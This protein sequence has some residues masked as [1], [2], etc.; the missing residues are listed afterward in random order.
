LQSAVLSHQQALLD[1]NV[2]ENHTESDSSRPPPK[3]VINKPIAITLASLE[4]PNP[5]YDPNHALPF[6]RPTKHKRSDLLDIASLVFDYGQR[7]IATGKS[8]LRTH[9]QLHIQCNGELRNQ[10]HCEIYRLTQQLFAHNYRTKLSNYRGYMMF[11]RKHKRRIPRH[12]IR[13]YNNLSSH[14]HNPHNPKCYLSSGFLSN[15]MSFALCTHQRAVRDFQYRDINNMTFPYW[16]T[17]NYL[18]TQAHH[19]HFEDYRRSGATW[20]GVRTFLKDFASLD[21]D[22]RKRHASVLLN[23][24]LGRYMQLANKNKTLSSNPSMKKLYENAF[25]SNIAVDVGSFKRAIPGDLFVISY[26]YKRSLKHKRPYLYTYQHWGLIVEPN[27]LSVLHNQTPGGTWGDKYQQWGIQHGRY[28]PDDLQYEWIKE[29][30]RR[31]YVQR[32]FFV[33]RVNI[34]YMLFAKR[35]GFNVYQSTNRSLCRN[36][37]KEYA[38]IYFTNMAKHRKKV[39]SPRDPNTPPEQGI[40]IHSELNAGI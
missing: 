31:R 23:H 36:W 14:R 21:V 22:T 24:I 4:L 25:C 15:C 2:T 32:I 34:H 39:T 29:K 11:H 8:L 18:T 12:L 37:I 40:T 16:G 10:P 27:E 6:T 30:R 28:Q 35:H 17:I 38:D 26:L 1:P 13:W 3:P 33:N 5:S 20:P 19:E 9:Q 7:V